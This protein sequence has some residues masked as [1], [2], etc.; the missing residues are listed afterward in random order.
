M[1]TSAASLVCLTIRSW[2]LSTVVF[3]SAAERIGAASRKAL[4]V[5][6]F[7]NK[8]RYSRAGQRSF[9]KTTAPFQLFWKEALLRTHGL[10]PGNRLAGIGGHAAHDSQQRAGGLAL[11][12]IDGLAVADSGEESVMFRLIHVDLLAFELPA[13]LTF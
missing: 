9:G 2:S 3:S 10:V 12:I 1:S 11:A 6:S 4:N 8:L 13:F 7:L 5:T